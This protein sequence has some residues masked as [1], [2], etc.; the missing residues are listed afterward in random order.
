MQECPL[1]FNIPFGVQMDIFQTHA[2]DLKEIH[3]VVRQRS[4]RIDERSC[5]RGHQ[6]QDIG[7]VCNRIA[8]IAGTAAGISTTLE[9]TL[10]SAVDLVWLQ[11]VPPVND[12]LVDWHRYGIG[13]D[14]K[15]VHCF[16]PVINETRRHRLKLRGFRPKPP[17]SLAQVDVVIV[18]V[19]NVIGVHVCGFLR[20]CH[21]IDRLFLEAMSKQIVPHSVFTPVDDEEI[22][23]R[24]TSQPLLRIRAPKPTTH[25]GGL[26]GA[27]ALQRLEAHRAMVPLDSDR[28]ARGVRI[29][30]Q[31]FR[32]RLVVPNIC[33]WIGPEFNPQRHHLILI[34]HVHS[35]TV[36]QGSISDGAD[37]G[38]A[39]AGALLA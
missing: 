10:R 35:H 26:Y 13:F 29:K 25:C 4:D 21:C 5:R 2:H 37:L 12:H 18:L 33:L 16:G 23:E 1:R 6:R 9:Q 7:R 27:T 36:G 31:L 15:G 32:Q 8:G 28:S 34:E 38:N 30:Q 3:A 17:P 24:L 22:Y 19:V 11:P 39:I 20:E 14:R